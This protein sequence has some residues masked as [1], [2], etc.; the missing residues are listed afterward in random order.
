MEKYKREGLPSH[1]GLFEATVIVSDLNNPKSSDL[2]DSWYKEF[3]DSNSMRDQLALP[4]VIWKKGFSIE[5][6]G[7]LGDN[8]K[9]NPMFRWYGHE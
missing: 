3:S 9:R 1:F 4:Y 8:L 6:I 5:D 7:F 2:L